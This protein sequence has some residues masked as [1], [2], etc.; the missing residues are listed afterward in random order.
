MDY[1]SF[2]Y[3]SITNSINI[4]M[5][6]I[7]PLIT[8]TCLCAALHCLRQYLIQ[9]S[10]NIDYL[11]FIEANKYKTPTLIRSFILM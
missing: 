7:N 5:K 11:Q 10:P 1:L 8:L 6:Y 3:V 2:D 9:S 4:S